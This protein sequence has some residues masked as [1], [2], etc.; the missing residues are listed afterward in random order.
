MKYFGNPLF[1][2]VLG[3]ALLQT[4]A[5]ADNDQPISVEQL[6]QNA[7]HL[8]KT[9]FADFK[10]VFAEMENRALNKSYEVK[11]AN[12]GSIEFNKKGEWIEIDCKNKAV[13]KKFI[14]QP[15]LK[16]VKKTWAD[17]KIV[18]IEKDRK[19]YEVELSSGLEVTFD[20]NFKVIDIDD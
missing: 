13:P 2:A 16:H 7:Q 12:G 8:L 19:H 14:P 9:D 11:F 3:L 15:I 6:P 4:P 10:V 18:K 17:T 5:F 1:V 20:K